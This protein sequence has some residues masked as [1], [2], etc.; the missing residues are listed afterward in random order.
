MWAL[1]QFG[2][3]VKSAAVPKHPDWVQDVLEFLVV[4]GYFIVNRK[5][6]STSR[7]T[8]SLIHS[9]PVTSAINFCDSLFRAQ[10]L[11]FLTR[12]GILVGNA[13]KVFSGTY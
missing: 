11:F 9:R 3:L 8:V 4:H 5:I 13:C 12:S 10:K 7:G 2:A 6:K 1:E